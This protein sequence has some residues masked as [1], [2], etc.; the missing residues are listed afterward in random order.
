[1]VITVNGNPSYSSRLT[2]TTSHS[3][4]VAEWQLSSEQATL[5]TIESMGIRFTRSGDGYRVIIND[6]ETKY[7]ICEYTNY[8]SRQQDEP[9]IYLSIPS[10]YW[11]NKTSGRLLLRF[12]SALYTQVYENIAL[13]I[14]LKPKATISTGTADVVNVGATQTITL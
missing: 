1:M 9:P 3:D 7:D 8:A 12:Y 11:E 4:S 6:K 13:E 14:V 10:T 2:N 5:Y